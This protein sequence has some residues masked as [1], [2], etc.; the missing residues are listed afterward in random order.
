MGI[1]LGSSLPCAG[2]TDRAKVD[3]MTEPGLEV[4]SPPWDKAVGLKAHDPDDVHEMPVEARP[5]RVCRRTT[6][7]EIERA[8]LNKA[9]R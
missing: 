6:I 1:R 3:T 8:G 7:D 2:R 4:T 9:P 5:Y